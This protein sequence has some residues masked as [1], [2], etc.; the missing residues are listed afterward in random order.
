[1]IPRPAVTQ[2]RIRQRSIR[3]VLTGWY[4]SSLAVALCLFSA[5]LY[6]T[7]STSLLRDLDQ[8]IRLQTDRVTDTLFAF[9]RAER[10]AAMLGPGNW[11]GAPAETFR[12][13]VEQGQLPGLVA[14]WDQKTGQL[15]SGELLQL[16]ARDGRPLLA[17]KAFTDNDLPVNPAAVEK[18]L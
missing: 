1:M 6:A 8:A 14:R 2:R 5:A 18:A 3:Q 11:T 15:Q 7:I 16:L 4:L 12:S 17:S 10:A 13:T 9:W